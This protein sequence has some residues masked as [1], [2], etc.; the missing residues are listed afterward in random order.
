MTALATRLDPKLSSPTTATTA[1][2]TAVSTDAGGALPSYAP[3]VMNTRH[4]PIFE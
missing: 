4:H 1:A 2:I 3:L